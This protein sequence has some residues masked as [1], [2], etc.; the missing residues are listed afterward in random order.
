MKCA[1]QKIIVLGSS[2]TFPNSE[3]GPQVDQ[4]ACMA[5]NR[6][7]IFSSSSTSGFNTVLKRFSSSKSR[8]VAKRVLSFPESTRKL[9]PKLPKF[10]FTIFIAS[11][12]WPTLPSLL[13]QV[14]PPTVTIWRKRAVE[15]CHS[16]RK[17][18]L[19]VV[20][21]VCRLQISTSRS[22]LIVHTTKP[23]SPPVSVLHAAVR[24]KSAAKID[25][26]S[27]T[28]VASSTT[29]SA[30]FSF[31]TPFGVFGSFPSVVRA[32]WETRLEIKILNEQQR[33]KQQRHGS[34]INKYW[35]R[36]SSNRKRQEN[37]EFRCE[38]KS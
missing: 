30:V 26:L 19:S 23:A 2:A 15:K 14:Q 21:K 36:P 16:H 1:P 33:R 17:H 4:A 12:N 13:A 8:P 5:T 7:K 24:F 34:Q 3:Q 25:D 18:H 27:L 22:S 11:D 37:K 9:S 31:D 38:Y 20:V 32:Q 29:S 28:A 35:F 6:A 10:P